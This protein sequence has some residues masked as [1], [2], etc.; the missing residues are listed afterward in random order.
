VAKGD[1]EEPMIDVEVSVA[2]LAR[3]CSPFDGHEWECDPID[4]AEVL[5]AAAEE[6][7]ETESWQAVNSRHRGIPFD[8]VGFHVGRLAYLY[9][10]P[11]HNPVEL[12]IE[13]YVDRY[14]DYR[15]VRMHDGN[16]RLGAAMLREDE[17]IRARVPECFLEDLREFLPSLNV[18]EAVSCSPGA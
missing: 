2:D 7:F 13:G 18:V 16:H 15:R 9:A 1:Y 14:G 5:E 11:D 4:P 6:V 12:E 10:H 17:V 8:D 3:L